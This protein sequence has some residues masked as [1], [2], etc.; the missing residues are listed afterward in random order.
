MP[1]TC[2]AC[3]FKNPDRAKFCNECGAAL[4]PKRE[5]PRGL[6]HARTTERRH[7][8]VLFADIQG[9]TSLS[10]QIDPEELHEIMDPI[11]ATMARAVT[12]HGGTVAKYLGDSVMA[13]F[14]VPEAHEDDEARAVR[15]ALEL[16]RRMADYPEIEGRK[17]AL[18]IG[19]NAGLV[20]AG[21]IGAAQK[22]DFDALGDTVNVAARLQGRA[23][24]GQVF[25]SDHVYR[26]ARPQFNWE[27]VGPF[28]LK[29]VPYLVHAYNVVGERDPLEVAKFVGA[30]MA[31]LCGREDEMDT[32]NSILKAVANSSGCVLGV[33]GE[34]GVGKSRLVYELRA[35]AQDFGFG[36][37]VGRTLS[38]G[39]NMPLMP[40]KEIVRLFAGLKEHEEAGF[41]RERV[42]EVFSP[43]WADAE[44]REIR[45]TT[46]AWF[47]G[48]PF[49]DS[50]VENL[51]GKAKQSLLEVSLNE[52]FVALTSGRKI[53]KPLVVVLE[54]MH[55]ADGATRDWVVQFARLMK[56][57]PILLVLVYRPGLERDWSSEDLAAF[58]EISLAPIKTG[59][60][61]EMV[62]SI[63][64]VDETPAELARFVA[65]KSQG[66][67]FFA[68]ELLKH[69]LEEGVVA[70]EPS[71]PG[72]PTTATITRP[73][74][75]VDIPSSVQ[76]LILSR[77]DRLETA[78]RRTLQEASVVGRIFLKRI[79]AEISSA[80]GQFSR[81]L[82]RLSDLEMIFEQSRLPEL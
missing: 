78:T 33:R 62:S 67:P 35:R 63:L 12:A 72:A 50:V 38:Y 5:K 21:D 13:L 82:D 16:H 81:H 15:C 54:D 8:T 4:G 56:D 55:W 57:K 40:I 24:A 11:Y 32:V 70:R 6:R 34:A 77:V 64:V 28:E 23:Q 10:A 52:F 61:G 39:Q 22:S 31:K 18:T 37:L 75:T 7:A 49:A 17:L 36:T 43:C 41:A 65:Q 45:V 30:G 53:G 9:Y 42:R 19:V 73:L 26:R 59:A 79:L 51:E 27:P 58:S 48:Y 80:R 68:E 74:D 76:A 66:N 60:V 69:L 29:N 20:V 71:P 3:G 25:A 44:I 1:L 2:P 47:L 46:L 14:G